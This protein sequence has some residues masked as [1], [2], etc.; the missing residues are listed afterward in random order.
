MRWLARRMVAI[1][2]ARWRDRYGD[3][4][5][6]LVDEAR[7]G[8][9]EIIDLALAAMGERL[10][11]GRDMHRDPGIWLSRAASVAAIVFALPSAMFVALNLLLYQFGVRAESARWWI[12]N[13][14]GVIEMLGYAGGPMLAIG[15]AAIAMGRF[16]LHRG[17]DGAVVVTARLRPTRLAILA[18]G[19][20]GIVLAIIV[21]YGISENL[22]A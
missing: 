13:S 9:R 16:D 5:H 3:E 15:L 2:P 11:E 14:S 22:L 10:Q 18:L 17:A 21:G 8:P 6:G 7:I 19:L 4:L 12:E 20:G 1:Y